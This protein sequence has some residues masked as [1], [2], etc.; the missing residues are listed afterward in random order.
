MIVSSCIT[1]NRK[2]F[3]LVE[4]LT[5]I[6]VLGL[7]AFLLVPTIQTARMK[8]NQAACASNLRQIG[9]ALLLY[10]NDN[11]GS[12]PDIAGHGNNDN[13]WIIKLSSYLDDV[14]SIRVS[15]ADP[16][17]DEKLRADD[18]T[19]Y[20]A[21]DLIL[22]APQNEI[23]IVIGPPRNL[24][25][26]QEPSQTRLFFTASDRLGRALT[27]DHIH[28]TN[29]TSWSNLLRDVAPDFHR[30]G[31]KSE[32]RTKGS[33]NILFADGRVESVPAQDLKDLI[34]AGINPAKPPEDV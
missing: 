31:G 27:G 17:R 11:G 7:L 25:H 5:V 1:I 13:S 21:N 32:D 22:G 23:G 19:S 8:A 28:G 4:L 30:M 16:L 6:A 20:V 15:P 10:A 24:H 12:L 9:S 34:D 2:A 26:L 3:T 18:N 33:S 29:W 14:D